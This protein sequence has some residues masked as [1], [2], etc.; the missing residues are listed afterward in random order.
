MT[1]C[2]QNKLTKQEHFIYIFTHT[3]LSHEIL[4]LNLFCLN[5]SIFAPYCI[6]RLKLGFFVKLID[7]KV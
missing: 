1:K 3:R 4:D 5:H 6:N 7:Y 2:T